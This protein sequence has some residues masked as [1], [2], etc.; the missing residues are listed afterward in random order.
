M[1]K[2]K[3]KQSKIRDNTKTVI[4][5]ITVLIFLIITGFYLFNWYINIDIAKNNPI[6]DYTTSQTSQ[7][8]SQI[9]QED[10]T[11]TQVIEEVSNCV[12]GISKLKENGTSIFLKDGIKQLGLEQ[13]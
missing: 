9:K 1:K 13:E 10:K 3:T 11:I 2:N 5:T 4:I 7:I 6:G 12:V 8:V